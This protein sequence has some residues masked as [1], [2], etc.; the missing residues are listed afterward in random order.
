MSVPRCP[1]CQ[2][3]YNY[4]R[5]PYILQPCSH[6]LCKACVDEYITARGNSLCPKC[7]GTIERHTVNFDLKEICDVVLDGWKETLMEVLSENPGVTVQINDSLLPVSQLIVCRVTGDRNLYKPLVDLVRHCDQDEVYS[8]VDALQ[9]PIGWDVDRQ[10][11]R[12]LR[13]YDFLEKHDAGW[14]L[15]FI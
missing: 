15:E 8:W 10:V 1:I 12:L 3:K 6:G 9:F 11:S 13:R 5:T 2:N 14:L 4:I 7:R